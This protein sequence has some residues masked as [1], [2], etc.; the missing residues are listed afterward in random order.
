MIHIITGNEAAKNLE[1]A[2]ELD[3]NLRGEIV[4][5]QDNLSLGPVCAEDEE[6]KHNEFRTAFWKH[7]LR[8]DEIDYIDENL[9]KLLIVKAQREEEPVCFWLSPNAADVCAY[10]WLLPYFKAHP[11][12][13]HTINIIGLPFLNEKGQLFYPTHFSQIPAK[14]FI[15]TKRLLKEV[16]LA[17]YETEGDEWQ[18]FVT[19]G[20]TIRIY[21]GGK[22][23]SSKDDTFF[24]TQI[25]NTIGA[26]FQKA[27]KI[28]NEVVK[29]STHFPNPA[30]I[31]NRIREMIASND[32][33][34]QGDL[35]KTAKDFDI[36]KV[37]EPATA[38]VAV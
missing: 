25:K 2:F 9:V 22:K 10:F 24:D 23:I 20:K 28:V 26:D 12:M 19:E 36:K 14:E 27:S 4:I 31:E 7:L 18:R 32:I 1:A 38:E 5:L 15:K 11:G 17:E 35:N 21:E 29:K 33:M 16:T 3:E 13:L 8:Q 34:A 6:T 37:G 30:F